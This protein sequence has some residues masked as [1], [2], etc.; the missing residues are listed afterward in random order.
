[1]VAKSSLQPVS[2]MPTIL[3]ECPLIVEP[4]QDAGDPLLVGLALLG[5]VEIDAEER[6]ARQHAA[7][8]IQS[9]GLCLRLTGF[10]H[11]SP[12]IGRMND[13]LQARRRLHHVV[14]PDQARA[15][16]AGDP[17]SVCGS[18]LNVTITG[19]ESAA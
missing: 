18:W 7:E 17:L 15:Y 1:M 2:P 13:V 4:L 5:L 8:V 19:R 11:H 6:A 14:D 16:S 12:R 10:Q 9:A 3:V